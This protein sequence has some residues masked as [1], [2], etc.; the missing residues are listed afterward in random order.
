MGAAGMHSYSQDLRDRVLWALDRG[1]KPTA[2]ARRLE[3]SRVWVYQ[4]QERR[5]ATGLRASFQIGGHR[6]SRI[7]DREAALRAWIDKEPDLSLTEICARLAELGVSIKIGALWHQLNKWGLT[8]K[9]NPA[10]QRARA[11]GRGRGAPSMHRSS[12]HNERR[13][14]RVH[15]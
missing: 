2:I 11:R 5:Q 10:R 8:F 14:A 9:K 1:E 13:K 6:R 7:A 15:R 4:V 3:V 12:A